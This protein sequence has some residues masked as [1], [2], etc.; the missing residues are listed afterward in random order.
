[1]GW[2]RAGGTDSAEL[3]ARVLSM[4]CGCGNTVLA[5]Q[6]TRLAQA[7]ERSRETKQRAGYY[8]VGDFFRFSDY[9]F[10]RKFRQIEK[11]ERVR[12]GSFASETFSSTDYLQMMLGLSFARSEQALRCFARFAESPTLPSAWSVVPDSAAAVVV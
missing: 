3:K 8:Y 12:P 10:V 9:Q 6:H 1:M 4:C 2:S 5:G 11:P 7:G